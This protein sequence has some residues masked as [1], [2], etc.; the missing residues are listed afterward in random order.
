[1]EHGRGIVAFYDERANYGFIEPD[2]ESGDVVFSLPP[3]SE[4][5]TVGDTVV[6]DLIPRPSVTTKGNEALR[7]RR[8][9]FAAAAR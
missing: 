1:M 3:G 6:Y 2:D 9:G 7:V 4:P 5:V 8:V